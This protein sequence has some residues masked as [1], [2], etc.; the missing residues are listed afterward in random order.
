[1]FNCMGHVHMYFLLYLSPLLWFTLHSHN[2][3]MFYAHLHVA[4]LMINDTKC[5][6]D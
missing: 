1:M 2:E 5:T 6:R 4:A 3:I